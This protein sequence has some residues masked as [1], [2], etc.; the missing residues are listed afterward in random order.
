MSHKSDIRDWLKRGGTI[1]PVRALFEFGCYRL[2]ARIKE[3]RDEGYPIIT[4]MVGEGS[5][6]W[7]EYH[8]DFDKL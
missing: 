3:L 5:E 1:S 2:A 8:L 6:R 4:V 7:A